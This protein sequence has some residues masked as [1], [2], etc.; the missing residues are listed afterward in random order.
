ML[1]L[2]FGFIFWLLKNDSKLRRL[3]STAAWIPIIWLALSGGRDLTSWLII[4]GFDLGSSVHG[5]F[6]D[7]AI[8]I[9]LMVWS[10]A[11][12]MK[13]QFSWSIFVSRNKMLILVYLYLACSSFWAEFGSATLGRVIKDF[14]CALVGLVILTEAS[15]IDALRIIFVRLSYFVL[16]LSII[17]IKWFP[18]IGRGEWNAGDSFVQGVSTHKNSLGQLLL[19]YAL[20]LIADI[21]ALQQENDPK[22]Y[23]LHIWIRKGLIA[24]AL[25]LLLICDSMTSNICLVLGGVLFWAT[26]MIAKLAQ[27]RKVFNISVAG[28]LVVLALNNM[29]QISGNLMVAVG[30]DPTMTGRS[31]IWAMVKET[32]LKPMLGYGYWS[33]WESQEALPVIEFNGGH[34]KTVHNGYREMYLDGGMVGVAL[35]LLLVAGWSYRA[36]SRGIDGTLMGRLTLVI[37]CVAMFYNWSETAFFRRVPLWILLLLLMIDYPTGRRTGES[38]KRGLSPSPAV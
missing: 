10:F 20:I 27:P 30:R 23:R 25:W 2:G 34:L 37:W 31:G 35:L 38:S 14:G 13:R 15:P 5:N 11:V 29:F 22:Q 3:P 24:L 16:I 33:Y 7:S 19:V 9:A 6:V 18:K 4:M 21:F 32:K 28:L 8:T 1:L 26:K 36:I 12:L 17:F